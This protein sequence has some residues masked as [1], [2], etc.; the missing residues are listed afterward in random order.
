VAP[1][2]YFSFTTFF[3]RETV[4]HTNGMTFIMMLIAGMENR[5]ILWMV[6]VYI[7]SI[8]TGDYHFPIHHGRR[9][10]KSELFSP[11]IVKKPR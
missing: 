4:E 10:C 6:K 3:Y 7:S 1:D 9:A 2:G 11:P 5:I 8:P